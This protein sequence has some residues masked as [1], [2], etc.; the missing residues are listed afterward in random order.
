[1]DQREFQEKLWK[2]LSDWKDEL[3]ELRPLAEK[4]KEEDKTLTGGDI[5]AHDIAEA[6][7]NSLEEAKNEVDAINDIAPEAWAERGEEIRKR[8]E[9][10]FTDLRDRFEALTESLKEQ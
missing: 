6:L 7:T 3:R 9:D 4:K 1:M 5:T 2:Q 10:N 8:V